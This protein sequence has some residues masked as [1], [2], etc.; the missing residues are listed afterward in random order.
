MRAAGQALQ[1]HGLGGSCLWGVGNMMGLPG[2]ARAEDP[3]LESLEGA[4]AGHR[5][6]LSGVA[7]AMSGHGCWAW[8]GP[9]QD[10]DVCGVLDLVASSLPQ[11]TPQG[12]NRLSWVGQTQDLSLRP[13]GPWVPLGCLFLR[14]EVLE[15]R[16]RPWTG[17]ENGC[18]HPEAL[19]RTPSLAHCT[20][21]AGGVWGPI[22]LGLVPRHPS[23]EQLEA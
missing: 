16:H 5:R 21:G 23:R 12:T 17:M 22:L 19:G 6:P 7:P 20:H 15:E 11:F 3:R 4:G 9:G 10:G 13:L 8:L 1:L 14:P 18:P 2:A